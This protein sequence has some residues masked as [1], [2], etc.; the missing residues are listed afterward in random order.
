M[1]TYSLSYHHL[2]YLLCICNSINL[3]QTSMAFRSL[4]WETRTTSQLIPHQG[5]CLNPILMRPNIGF[6]SQS[7]IFY[8]LH[9]CPNFVLIHFYYY[10]MDNKKIFQCLTSDILNWQNKMV[11]PQCDHLTHKAPGLEG[12]GELPDQIQ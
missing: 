11:I 4:R 3:C 7:N 1:E 2:W 5:M 9:W 12:E 8:P 10:Q 6:C